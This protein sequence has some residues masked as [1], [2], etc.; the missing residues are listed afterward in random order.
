VT[1]RQLR[2]PG[3]FC[4]ASLGY[5]AV[6]VGA[7]LGVLNVFLFVIL[8]FLVVLILI[9]YEMLRKKSPGKRRSAEICRQAAVSLRDV[10]RLVF[11]NRGDG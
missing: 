5:S 4:F 2:G 11:D 8:I 10:L 7:V 6:V 3:E 1:V 9:Q